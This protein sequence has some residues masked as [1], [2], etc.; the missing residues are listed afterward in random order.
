L[1]YE[2][3]NYQPYV[4]AVRDDR[5][6]GLRAHILR[7]IDWEKETP[8]DEIAGGDWKHWVKRT[9]RRWRA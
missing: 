8:V 3:R 2:N 1:A 7:M 9:L 6:Y 5:P 4:A